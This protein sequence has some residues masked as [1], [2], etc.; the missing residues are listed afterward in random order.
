MAAINLSKIETIQTVSLPTELY[1]TQAK[2]TTTLSVAKS[3]LAA[4]DSILAGGFSPTD[5]ALIS[6]LQSAGTNMLTSIQTQINQV[7]TSITTMSIDVAIVSP[8]S[9]T[10]LS[11]F[12]NLV[13]AYITQINNIITQFNN[14][15]T[16]I[17]E[18]ADR[19]DNIQNEIGNELQKA[20]NKTINEW[21]DKI[22]EELE[23][24]SDSIFSSIFAQLDSLQVAA[25]NVENISVDSW[26]KHV[27]PYDV[28]SYK[29]GEAP[30]YNHSARLKIQEENLYRGAARKARRSIQSTLGS[31]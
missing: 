1:E 17:N 4:V 23:P 24:R 28:S 2:I 6:N 15:V 20:V 8:T 14:I 5:N 12:I 11:S 13:N 19:F 30:E 3:T 9:I 25:S 16:Q 10:T 7:V 22:G 29:P 31:I 21:T 18:L 26:R 27:P